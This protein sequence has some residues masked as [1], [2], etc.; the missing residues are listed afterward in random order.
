MRLRSQNTLQ[1]V[2]CRLV[3]LGLG[4]RSHSLQPASGL[5]KR[6][7]HILWDWRTGQPG[8]STESQVELPAGTAEQLRVWQVENS[9]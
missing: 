3:R 5:G 8:A 2:Q 4:I 9:W 6:G 7:L 1:I